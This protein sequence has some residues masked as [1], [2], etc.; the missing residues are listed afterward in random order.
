MNGNWRPIMAPSVPAGQPCD[1]AK[2]R[3]R[4]AERAESDRRGVEDQGEHQSFERGKADQDEKRR[5]DR[6]R[7][8]EAGNAFEQRAEAEADHH[9]HDAAIVGEM[10]ENPRPKGV[11][12]VRLDRDV[13][14]K[15]RVDDDPHHRPESEDNAGGDGIYGEGSG[16]VPH[17]DRDDKTNNE[18][19]QRRLPGRPAHDAE[20]HENSRDRKRRYDER[21]RQAARD[22]RQQ[23]FEHFLA[24]PSPLT[25][26]PPDSQRTTRPRRF[27]LRGAVAANQ[28]PAHWS[29]TRCGVETHRAE[30]ENAFH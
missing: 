11:E 19:R 10:V 5:S 25:D 23:L 24:S 13:I 29:D 27:L 21:K 8:A 3:H 22:R 30:T 4:N 2:R 17:R 14:E 6:D 1:R 16:K 9:E 7:R 15:Q 28:A 20:Q 12:A 18:T 26:E